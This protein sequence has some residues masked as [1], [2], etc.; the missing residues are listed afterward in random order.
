MAGADLLLSNALV[1]ALGWALVHFL[2]QGCVLAA[3]YWL[4]C[5]LSGRGSG[6]LRYWAG[7]CGFFLALVSVLITFAVYYEPEARFV[8]AP[9]QSEAINHFLVL[10]GS[11]PDTTSL[12]QQGLE[13]ALP[14]I[15]LVWLAGVLIHTARAVY[16]WVGIKRLVRSGSADIGS[17]LRSVFGDLQQ[18]LGLRHRVKVLKSAL[19]KVPMAVGWIRPVI[20]LPA[21]VLLQLPRD[22]IEMIIAHELGHIRRYDHLFNLFQIMTETLLFYH[23]AIAWMSSRVREERENCCD[24]LVVARCNKPATYAR[25]LANLEVMRS[26]ADT[27]ALAAGGGDLLGRIKRIIDNEL[28]RTPLGYAQV[29]VLCMVAACVGLAAHQGL[30]LSRQLN[31]VAASVRLQVS[32][33]EWE[34]WN[35]SRAAWASGMDIY[36]QQVR[37]SQ[38]TKWAGATDTAAGMLRPLG[39]P[40]PMP[41]QVPGQLPQSPS[42][43]LVENGRSEGQAETAVAVIQSGIG[44]ALARGP[45]HVA[46]M[47]SPAQT[48]Q[49]AA[50]PAPALR[51]SAKAP[52][53]LA[54]AQPVPLLALAPKYPWRAR[55]KGIEG[56]VELA[57]SLDSKGNVFGIEVVDSLPGGVFDRAAAKALKKWRF[58]EAGEPGKPPIRLVQK[59]DFELADQAPQTSGLPNP[60][61][62]NC[63]AAGHKSC[64]RIP[65]NAV[66][67]YVNPPRENEVLSRVN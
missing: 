20:L 44:V 60:G 24:D 10:S 63:V 55:A 25:A 22:Q 34:T 61:A 43:H 3:V 52:P 59:F 4:V 31:Q 19:V 33:V 30:S 64:R 27:L 57:F 23:P 45:V 53:G 18:L 58:A 42:E 47:P 32:D 16:G 17:S 38:N 14:L 13:P 37:V 35:A 8:V 39:L 21:S 62:R 65:P 56:F 54:V 41:S 28:P 66:V 6:H 49:F 36:A 67:V 29:S 2:W 26:H 1:A 48:K 5:T 11:W 40:D 9:V 12:L 50:N 15:V 46:D 51:E 7:I